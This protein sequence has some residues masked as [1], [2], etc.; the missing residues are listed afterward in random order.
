MSTG[1]SRSGGTAPS[2]VPPIAE[3][4]GR[5]RCGGDATFLLPH[6]ALML[7]RTLCALLSA[8]GEAAMRNGCEDAAPLP[9]LPY[10]SQ[11]HH[12]KAE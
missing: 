9:S 2:A 1:Q 7:R 3:H 11:E 12:N 4:C 6:T 5:A 10:T 8:S